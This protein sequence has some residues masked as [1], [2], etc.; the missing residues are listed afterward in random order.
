MANEKDLTP[1][2]VPPETPSKEYVG[3]GIDEFNKRGPYGEAILAPY[4]Q[5]P[6]EKRGKITREQ[7]GDTA[8]VLAIRAKHLSQTVGKK[9]F[10]ALYRLILSA[11]IAFDKAWPQVEAPSG[12]NVV[13]ALF[14]SLGSKAVSSITKPAIPIVEG[15]YTVVDPPSGD[16][17]GN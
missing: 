2:A 6:F 4:K 1:S 13:L 16:D 11:G 3:Q 5:H 10:N 12:N 9:D 7:W 8:Y 17:V 15:T 14:S